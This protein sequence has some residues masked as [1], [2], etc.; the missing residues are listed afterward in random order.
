MA[1]AE[2][3]EPGSNVLCMLPDTGER[4]LTTSLFDGIGDD[5]TAEEVRAPCSR[6][7]CSS[8]SSNSS[9]SSSSITVMLNHSHVVLH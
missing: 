9:S 2:K 6:R 8:S 4:Y 3:A 1:V 7:V 5:M